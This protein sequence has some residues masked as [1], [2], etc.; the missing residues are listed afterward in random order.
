MIADLGIAFGRVVFVMMFVLN[1][2][3]I[4]TWV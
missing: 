1:L 2:G 4:L 3:G